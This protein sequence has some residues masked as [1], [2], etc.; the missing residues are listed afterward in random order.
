MVKPSL[1]PKINIELP[2]DL[3]VQFNVMMEAMENYHKAAGHV[4]EAAM[5]MV[6]NDK[7]YSEFIKMP[8]RDFNQVFGTHKDF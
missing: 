7:I 6:L 8:P 5:F 1:T 2:A 3:A 4:E